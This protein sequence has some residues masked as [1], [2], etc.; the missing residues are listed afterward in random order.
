LRIAGQY[1][2][3]R[4]TRRELALPR[5]RWQELGA[6]GEEERGGDESL[7]PDRR[8]ETPEAKPWTW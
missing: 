6:N 2:A 8:E 1:K 7:L 3:S 4:S 5:K